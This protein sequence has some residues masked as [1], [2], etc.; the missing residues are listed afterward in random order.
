MNKRTVLYVHSASDSSSQVLLD[1]DALPWD[2]ALNDLVSIAAAADGSGAARPSTLSADALVLRVS[3]TEKPRGNVAISVLKRVADACGLRTRQP[4]VV[5]SALP[6]A[7]SLDV[8][9]LSFRDQFATLPDMWRLRDMTRGACLHVGSELKALHPRVSVQSL[10]RAGKQV[11]SGVS[12]AATRFV[13]RS[14]SARIIWLVQMS[15][16]MWHVADDG[17]THCERLVQHVVSRVL[18]KWNQ[19]RVQHSLTIVL[20]ARVLSSGAGG[21]EGE[22]AGGG[23]GRRVSSSAERDPAAA[24]TDDEM[25]DWVVDNP[26]AGADGRRTK[27]R[28]AASSQ[29]RDYFHVAVDNDCLPLFRREGSGGEEGQWGWIAHKLRHAIHGFCEMLERSNGGGGG[30][31]TPAPSPS[32]S[33]APPI[34]LAPAA[35]GNFLEA[36]NLTLNLF[37]KQYMD[38]DLARTGSSMVVVTGASPPPPSAHASTRLACSLSD[39]CRFHRGACCASVRNCTRSPASLISRRPCTARRSFLR[40]I[41]RARTRALPHA[42]GGNGVFNASPRLAALTRRRMVENGIVCDL[43]CMS[44]PPLHAAPLLVFT[45]PRRAGAERAIAPTRAAQRAA[46]SAAAAAASGRD[47]SAAAAGRARSDG[48][49]YEVPVWL[50]V[51]YHAAWTSAARAARAVGEWRAGTAAGT[52]VGTAAGS[53][54]GSAGREAHYL[55]D[56]D[57]CVSAARRHVIGDGAF[58]FDL[59]SF[60]CSHSFFVC[61]FFCCL[62]SFVAFNSLR[63]VRLRSA[64]A[65]DDARRPR[66]RGEQRATAELAAAPAARAPAARSRARRGGVGRGARLSAAPRLRDVRRG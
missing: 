15:P 34:S 1:R 49:T 54:A 61:S 4:V 2:L 26:C 53:A 38:R 41:C 46:S 30:G 66:A 28:S 20:F 62:S 59:I 18:A 23:A 51:S 27:R 44:K 50:H 21:G 9:E 5:S 14:H 47:A 22:G 35:D 19:L 39:A 13:Y 6:A 58:D 25:P 11:R 43:V 55:L 29:P 10:Y 52:A 12:S 33:S 36:I 8:I 65:R 45:A 60:V 3:S 7:V 56:A 24:A 16:E 37:E 57:R 63:R 64:R 32:A 42:P 48:V 40:R 31:A 17:G